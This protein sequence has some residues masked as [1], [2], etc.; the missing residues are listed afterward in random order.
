M[1]TCVGTAQVLPAGSLTSP[2]LTCWSG[3]RGQAVSAAWLCG[4]GCYL[5]SPVLHVGLQ[6]VLTSSLSFTGGVKQLEDN[7]K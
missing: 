3:V 2:T 5:L 6:E 1:H 7:R 4:R